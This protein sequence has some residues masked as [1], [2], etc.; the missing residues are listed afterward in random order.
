VGRA[1]R[2]QGVNFINILRSASARIDPK[3]IKRY[4]LLDLVLT[5]EGAMGTKASN[6]YVDEIGQGKGPFK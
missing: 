3:S 5:L 4:L 6:K 1:N 2:P